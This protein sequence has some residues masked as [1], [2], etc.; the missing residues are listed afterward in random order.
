MPRAVSCRDQERPAWGRGLPGPL[1]SSLISVTTWL[2][3]QWTSI[4]S[5]IKYIRGVGISALSALTC[6]ESKAKWVGQR[7]R[8][9][10]ELP[11][12]GKHSPVSWL[13]FPRNSLEDKDLSANTLFGRWSQQASE[14]KEESETGKKRKVL[15][16]E[17]A[18][19]WPR[20]A[21]WVTLTG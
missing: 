19:M 18:I 16:C 3:V 17:P 2:C 6:F 8:C 13:D 9:H 15:V 4:S 11:V 1:A 12:N 10:K 7:I 14:G 20:R 21:S 5:Y